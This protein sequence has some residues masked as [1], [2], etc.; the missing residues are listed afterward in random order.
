MTPKFIIFKNI[1]IFLSIF[2]PFLSQGIELNFIETKPNLF[3]HYGKHEDSNRQNLGDIANVSFL[4]G[5]KSVLVVDTGGSP[6]IGKEIIKEIKK[7]T[8]KPI[9]HIVISHG[10][11]DHFLGTSSFIK[12]KSIQK[13]IGHE[14]LSRSLIL[15][16]D[17]YQKQSLESTNDS[18]LNDAFLVLPNLTIKSGESLTIDLGDRPIKIKAWRSGHTDNDLSI[19]DEKTKTV[20]TENVFVHRTPS[21]TASILGWKKTL[22]EMLE[23][24]FEYIIPGHGEMKNKEE[25]IKP[26]LNYFNDLITQVRKFHNDSKDLDYAV[27]NTLVKNKYNWLLFKEYHQR[28][29]SRTYT[30]LEWE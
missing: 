1:F 30:E 4:I 2:L 9:S 17:F 24:E 11:P 3:V 28:N 25:A 22:E 15:N 10:H 8:N 16:F 26:M 21:I 14:K 13:I 19:Y 5:K 7:K 27:K 6:A 20:L 23:M 29:V 18:S 12:E